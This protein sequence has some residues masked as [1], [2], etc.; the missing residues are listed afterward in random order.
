MTDLNISP[1]VRLCRESL[2]HGPILIHER[3]IYDYELIFLEKGIMT[4]CYDGQTY[5][6]AEG[7]VILLRPGHSHTI[8]MD[9]PLVS[10]PHV[11]FDPLYDRCRETV[12]IS[13]SPL[14]AMTAEQRA[15]IMQAILGT[16]R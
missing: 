7:D 16:F 5:H 9:T 10:Q 1:Y 14:S 15:Q 3:V 6:C 8:S 13:F 12:P 4:I 2:I 11:H